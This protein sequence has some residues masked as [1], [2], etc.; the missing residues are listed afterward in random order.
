MRKASA[1]F[2][3]KEEALWYLLLYGKVLF[4][5][6][7]VKDMRI[8]SRIGTRPLS[9]ELHD[10]N[11][12]CEKG[13]AELI[14]S[15]KS[16][17][18]P[19]QMEIDTDFALAM[20]ELVR[21]DLRRDGE[22]L[23]DWEYRYLANFIGTEEREELHSL[24]DK[25]IEPIREQLYQTVQMP[26]EEAVT[27]DDLIQ[28]I[29]SSLLEKRRIMPSKKYFDRLREVVLSRDVENRLKDYT[30]EQLESLYQKLWLIEWSCDRLKRLFLVA[31]HRQADLKIDAMI[32]T[33]PMSD[34]IT[35]PRGLQG[36]NLYQVASV[37]LDEVELFPRLNTVTDVER[38]LNRKY[39]TDL[40][41][42][43]FAWGEAV[44]EGSIKDAEEL[45]GKVRGL[46]ARTIKE[47]GRWRKASFTLGIIQKIATASAIVPGWNI[48]AVPI[49]LSAE[50]GR[51]R[52]AKKA[53]AVQERRGWLLFGHDL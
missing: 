13:L 7:T 38:H 18:L 5:N 16:E 37:F 43:I 21:S 23:S 25:E 29:P 31:E 19:S 17:G 12:L 10:L 53:D 42:T 39:I 28:N 44:S 8:R 22:F 3:L 2:K 11:R 46:V 6:P 4:A 30:V 47:I 34:D 35:I 51:E 36:E 40:R 33:G 20:K 45:R 26:K 48:V 14:D 41:E 32:P 27:M 1:L 49:A 52:T 50:V 24:F 9:P 15:P